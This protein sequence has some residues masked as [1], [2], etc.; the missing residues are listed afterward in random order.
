MREVLIVDDDLG[1]RETT[2]RMLR[3]DGYQVTTV[4]SVRAALTGLRLRMPDVLLLDPRIGARV[5][6][7]RQRPAT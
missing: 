7:G 4:D 1:F 3:L 6:R 2:T 5:A